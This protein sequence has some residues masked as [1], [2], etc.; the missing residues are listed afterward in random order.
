VPGQ[1][2]A[3]LRLLLQAHWLA[4]VGN[5]VRCSGSR[6]EWVDQEASEGAGCLLVSRFC[7]SVRK[8]AALLRDVQLPGEAAAATEAAQQLQQQAA[9]L[10]ERLQRQQDASP[11]GTAAEGT[12]TSATEQPA[13]AL[14]HRGVIRLCEELQKAFP[15]DLAQQLQQFGE[16]VC[17]QLPISLWCC[18][19][20][21]TNLQQQSELELVGGK[22]CICFGCRT[23]RFCSRQCLEQCWKKQLH[24]GVCKRI[25][26]ARQQQQ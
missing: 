1:L 26:A 12:K 13:A 19:P 16:A 9:G 14:A 25:A 24:K 2:S 20:C 4:V 10:L 15:G 8:C 3:E 22:G 11:S 21:C 6:N 7:I 23:A 17:H 5:I 18:N